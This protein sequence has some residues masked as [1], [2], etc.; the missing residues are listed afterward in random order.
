MVLDPSATCRPNQD[1]HALTYPAAVQ[2]QP[3][4]PSGALQPYES[5]IETHDP[6]I[7]HFQA[8]TTTPS[9]RERAWFQE[10]TA[11]QTFQHPFSMP[12]HSA[13]GSDPTTPTQH[14][15]QQRAWLQEPTAAPTLVQEPTAAPTFQDPFSMSMPTHS[16]GG[17]YPTTSTQHPPPHLVVSDELG[18]SA[19]HS[20]LRTPRRAP[21]AHLNPSLDMNPPS[22]PSAAAGVT[23]E[24][25]FLRAPDPFLFTGIH[26]TGMRS[27]G[28]ESGSSGP[29]FSPFS[30]PSFTPSPAGGLY[31]ASPVDF[32]M[33][34]DAFL[35]GFPLFSAPHSHSQQHAHAKVAVSGTAHT[36]NTIPRASGHPRSRGV[37]TP[38][39]GAFAKAKLFKHQRSTPDIEEQRWKLPYN[40]PLNNLID[41]IFLTDWYRNDEKEPAFRRGLGLTEGLNGLNLKNGQSIFLAFRD[42]KQRCVF[43]SYQAAKSNRMVKHMR[44]HFGLRPYECQ[45]PRCS[46]GNDG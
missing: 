45:C 40:G 38:H 15:P 31:E 8:A 4:L 37:V 18:P 41:R 1:R 34:D 11:P 24:Y 28:S 43:C 17:P 6:V 27:P 16:A 32:G 33:V 13:G 19:S 23:D 22:G 12:A 36:D 10:P 46:S 3:F 35:R 2:Q 14:L 29:L 5:Y 42:E 21:P 39:V 9:A 25:D 44:G 20:A 30:P 26:A 7:P